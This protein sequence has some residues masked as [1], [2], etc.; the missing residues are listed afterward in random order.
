MSQSGSGTGSFQKDDLPILGTFQ[1]G[2]SEAGSWCTG[3]ASYVGKMRR[4]CPEEDH[5]TEEWL[6]KGVSLLSLDQGQEVTTQDQQGAA[7]FGGEGS[8]GTAQASSGS[9]T[10]MPV[11]LDVATSGVAGLRSNSK[12]AAS[13][14]RVKKTAFLKA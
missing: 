12:R 9:Q 8:G 4:L 6:Q 7:G 11:H 14:Q 13:S 3:F 10:T 5:P 2:A 1:D